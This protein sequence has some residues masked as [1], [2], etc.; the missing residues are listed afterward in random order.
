[1]AKREK[2]SYGSGEIVDLGCR[3]LAIRWRE[4]YRDATGKTKQRKRYETLGEVSRRE[5]AKK[6]NE[7]LQEAQKPLAPAAEPVTFRELA[8]KWREHI[9]PTYKASVRMY[10]TGVLETHLIPKFGDRII[11]DITTLEIQAWVSDLRE[12]KYSPNTVE[13]LHRALTSIFNPAK[14]WYGLTPNPAHGVLIGRLKPVRQK[15]ALTAA[16]ACA[17]LAQLKLKARTMVAV[18]LTTGLRRGELEA[19]QWEHLNFKTG[20]LRI[21]QHHYRGHLDEPKTE[22]GRRTAI[23]PAEVMALVRE[24]K[25][26]SK[27]TK[28]SDFIFA[29]RKGKPPIGNLILRRHVYPACEVLGFPRAS[30]L[31]FRRTFDNWSHKN[32]IPAKDI[33]EMMGH[34]EVKMQFVY[35]VG[36]DEN[37]RIAADRLGKELGGLKNKLGRIGQFLPLATNRVN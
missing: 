32:G 12:E 3:R 7:K 11:Q 5:A 30:W 23:I 20:E 15:W 13:S 1:M 14:A 28:P 19:L 35:T 37:K 36:M 18:D 34:A 21:E 29:T 10:R 33:A 2:R 4:P 9:L 26:V 22:A 24:W 8:E 27:R 17:L 6:L 16:Q 31:T 25:R